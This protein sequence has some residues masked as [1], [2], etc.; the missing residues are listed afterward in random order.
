MVAPVIR[1]SAGFLAFVILSGLPARGDFTVAPAT[2]APPMPGMGTQ[3][4]ATQSPA[5]APGAEV[6]PAGSPAS[7]PALHAPPIFRAEQLD[8]LL[9]PIALYPD[10]LLAEILMAAT[11]PLEIVRARRW[12]QDSSHADL[13][14]A[15]L[16][17]ALEAE[18]WDPSVKS[19]V[20]FPQILRMMDDRL[21]WTE[22]LGNAFL[23]QQGDVMDAIQ[24]LRNQAAAAGTLWSN[25]Q[26]R[27]TTEG[28]GIVI[29]PTNPALIYP[30]VYN[31]DLVYGPWPYPD[32][33]PLDIVPPDYDIGFGLPFGIGFGIGFVVIQPFQCA[34]DWTQRR[35][36]LHTDKL[37]SSNRDEEERKA[38]IWQHDPAHR[39]GV[40]YLD[41]ASQ[42]RF[43]VFRDHPVSATALPRVDIPNRPVPAPTVLREPSPRAYATV[44]RAL[45]TRIYLHHNGTVTQMNAPRMMS[46]TTQRQA[47]AWM[48]SRAIIASNSRL[49]GGGA[50][51]GGSSRH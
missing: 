21:D 20:A 10:P 50:R 25:A 28:Q 5:P 23:A 41:L 22:Q 44:G 9:A 43:G 37:D 49:L 24:R 47:T 1:A 35:L 33:P 16:A 4:P 32:F 48:S 46:W 12:L 15:Q 27:V 39:H 29:E 14:G 11:Y 42:E 36:L 45:P 18:T 26:E 40:P 13:R 2:E 17:A 34:F 3:A 6:S 30:P 8:Q 31:P 51:F 38:D 19:L 7:T